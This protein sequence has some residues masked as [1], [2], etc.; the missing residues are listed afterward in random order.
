VEESVA[1]EQNGRRRAIY[2]LAVLALSYPLFFYSL[3][4]YS[5]KEPD[6][7]RYAEIPREMVETGDYLVPRLDYVRYFEKPPLLYWACALS[8]NVFG[9]SEWSFRFPNAL[10]ALLCVLATYLFAAR[11]FTNRT[12]FISAIML[13]TSF[14][15]FAMARIATIDML[16][17]FLLFA[18]V[19]CFYE[20]YRGERRLFLY[21]FSAALALAFLAKGPVAIV[22]PVA[23]IVLFLYFE[24]RLSFIRKLVSAKAFLL[25]AAIA[26]PWFV[27]VSL[28]EKEFFR[29]F[30]I[31][32][33]ILRFL[34]TKHKRSGPPY[35]YLPVLFGG[36]F[37]WSIFIPRA[38]V[39]FWKKK[40]L[41]LLSIWC[42]VVFTFFSVSGSKLPPYILP[43]FPALSIILGCLFEEMRQQ[44]IHFLVE[45][46]VYLLFFA[47]LAVGGLAV[48]SGLLD[49]HLAGI[50]DFPDLSA[51]IH[52]LALWMA[53]VSL[54]A[55]AVFAA[56]RMR[57]PGALFFL[58]SAF[59]L[60]IALGIMAHVQVVDRFNTTKQLALEARTFRKDNL[61]VVNYGSFDETLPFYLGGRTLLVDFKGELEM[62]SK[63]PDS[64]AA[65]LGQDEFVRLFRSDRPVLVVFKARRSDGLRRLGLGKDAPVLCRA[66]RC[67]MANR[68][69]MSLQGR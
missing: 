7:G 69:A 18:A 61:S 56:G 15:F 4:N 39:R 68:S 65:F 55:L 51:G 10:A 47:L 16:L 31:D 48:G 19:L 38:V 45:T 3:G 27:L 25:F 36:L 66:G 8:Y 12:G 52:S 28:R 62:G 53:V 30:F 1:L 58:L 5:L 50:V 13:A 32:Q 2:L 54:A 64:K 46:I 44:R 29:F 11:R 23:T 26:A 14:G 22:L 6:E 21:L 59:S 57:S 17:S 40:E 34:T 33:N 60:S 43:L 41:R 49:R 35:Y 9:V 63:Y 24:K 67:L 37:P 20:F 42:L